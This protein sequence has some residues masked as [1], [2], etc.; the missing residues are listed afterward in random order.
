MSSPL[1]KPIYALADS[2]L[3]FWDH[4]DGSLFLNRVFAAAGVDRPTVAYVGASNGDNMSVY[5]DIFLAAMDRVKAGECRLIFSSPGA[6]DGSFLEHADVI[7]LAGG[8]VEVGW[9]TFER[10]GIKPLIERRYHEGATLIGV[11]AGA[12]Q[13]GRGGLTDDGSTLVPTLGL[14][15]F[16][17]SAHEEREDWKSLR[18]ILQFAEQ[19]AQGIG[20]MSGGGLIFS[21][22]QVTPLRKPV[23]E[24]IANGADIRKEMV[25]PPMPEA[26]TEGP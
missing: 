21:E 2:S 3:L 25:Y 4:S 24:F 17:V 26:S 14:L 12:V 20:I 10:N 18:R 23:C 7:L 6:E 13:L 11:S 9:R 1:P 22:G 8:S 5:H 15:P 19:P 16:Y